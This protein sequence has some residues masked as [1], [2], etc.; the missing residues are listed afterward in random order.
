MRIHLIVPR[1]H[2]NLEPIVSAFIESKHQVYVYSFKR[3]IAEIR[4]ENANINF[5]DLSSSSKSNFIPRHVFRNLENLIKSLKQNISD[6]TND[7]VFTRSEISIIGITNLVAILV[8]RLKKQT[9][10]FTQYPIS[11][12]KIHQI[13]WKYIIRRILRLGYFSQVFLS[14]DNLLDKNE[15]IL[16]YSEK[17]KKCLNNH[18]LFIPLA[19]PKI[20]NENL[21]RRSNV[22][23]KSIVCIAKCDPRKGLEELIGM[24]LEL[25]ASLPIVT[26]LKL[27][28]QVLNKKQC[29]FLENLKEKFDMT[30]LGNIEIYTNVSPKEAREIIGSSDIFIL[31]SV[32]EPASFSQLEAIALGIPVILR[33]SNGSS[34]VLPNSFGVGKINDSKELKVI[35]RDFIANWSNQKTDVEKL[36]RELLSIIGA[37][38]I[39]EK[40]L[41]KLDIL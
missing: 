23:V 32:N 15:T 24:Y 26:K 18:D 28:V 1:Y 25:D 10:V 21:F 33:R 36:R 34:S 8:T 5:I 20:E 31:N 12:P 39:S 14:Y 16:E 11:N 7:V 37:D 19:M 9:V 13:V 3:S 4:S 29:I 30:S 40:W 35:T 2:T 17:L 38:V 41:K 6:S 22:D 27:V